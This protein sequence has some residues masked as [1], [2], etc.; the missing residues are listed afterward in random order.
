MV[1]QIAL[2]AFAVFAIIKTRK[3]YQTR[4]VSKYWFIVFAVFWTLV[5]IAAITPQTTDIV[6]SYVGVG[7][8]ADLL[9]YIGVV[10]LFYVVHRLLLKQQQLSDEITELVRQAAIER[11]S[12]PSNS[13]LTGGEAK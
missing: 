2:V 3:Q 9:V 7:R 10:V 1:F 11:V 5:A 13:P 6:A 4:K 8:G 12:T